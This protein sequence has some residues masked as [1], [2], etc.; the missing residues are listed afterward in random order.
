MAYLERATMWSYAVH[1]YMS[2]IEIHGVNNNVVISGGAEGKLN[3]LIKGNDCTV[4]IGKGTT[5]AGANLCCMGKGNALIIGEECMLADGLE[6]WNTDSH[7]VMDAHTGQAINNSKP[8]VVGNHV[9]VGKG[10]VILKGTTIG[11]GSI[12]GMHTVVTKDVPANAICV[13]NP[14]TVKKS[15]V[16][17]SRDHT[18]DF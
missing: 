10:A 12:I 4:R 15:G 9:W 14:G 6:I 8:V 7:F 16:T 5:I 1:L 2:E 17:W 11:D 13:G 18:I 3:L